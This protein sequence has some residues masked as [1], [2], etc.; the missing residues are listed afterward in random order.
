MKATF[1]V[2]TFPWMHY[3]PAAI[4]CVAATAASAIV[5]EGLPERLATSFGPAGQPTGWMAKESYTA[6]MLG[7]MWGVLVLLLALDRLLVY[8]SFP[9]PVLSAIAGATELLHLVIHLGIIGIYQMEGKSVWTTM[10]VVLALFVAY[11]VVHCRVA[12]R[13]GDEP[14]TPPLWTDFPPHGILSAVFFFVRP[15]FPEI[16]AHEEGLVLRAWLYT[17]AV[18]WD[19]IESVEHATVWEAMASMGVR[20]ASKPSRAVKLRLAGMK[21]P[22]IFSIE[23]ESRLVEEW[24]KRRGGG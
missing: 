9:V 22:L 14:E 1:P 18:P 2:R 24:K 13:R 12:R 20:I 15:F 19:A 17:F 3:L 6:F 4:F 10:P 8:G 11:I 21:L 7:A 16:R 5:Y 23:D